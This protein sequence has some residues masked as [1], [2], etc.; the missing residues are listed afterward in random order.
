M[1][2]GLLSEIVFHGD[3]GAVVPFSRIDDLRTD[4]IDIKKWKL[5]YRLV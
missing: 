4:I 2:K 1:I 5:S 3:K